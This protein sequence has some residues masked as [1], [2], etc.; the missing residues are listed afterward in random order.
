MRPDDLTEMQWSAL[1]E[2]G[3]VGAGHAA[4]AL[5]QLVGREIEL[6]VPELYLLRLAEVPE[7]LGGPERPAVGVYSRL[8]GEIRG[9]IL[10]VA[11]RDSALALDDM[12][13]DRGVGTTKTLDEDARRMISHAASILVSSYL[14]AV[15]RMTDLTVL[16]SG[17][18]F[19]FDMVGAI[20]QALAIDIGV[21]GEQALVALTRFCS[22]DDDDHD[23]VDAYIFFIPSAEDL[24]LMLGR[25]GVA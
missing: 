17:S 3:S 4:T 7:L 1:R 19:A 14:V 6:E 22:K 10:F 5:S 9:S 24:T 8:L 2:V 11:S 16:P 20:L 25:L 21:S 15:G 12:L 13:H 23:D 18:A